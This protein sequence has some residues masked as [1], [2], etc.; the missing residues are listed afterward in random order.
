MLLESRPM[1]CITGLLEKRKLDTT[2]VVQIDFL[3]V[4]HSFIHFN[5]KL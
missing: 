1:L 5:G 2:E 4:I 3:S